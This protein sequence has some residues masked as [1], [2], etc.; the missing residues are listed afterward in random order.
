MMYEYKGYT[1]HADENGYKIVEKSTG[2]EVVNCK[3]PNIT[4]A[5]ARNQVEFIVERL[6]VKY[7][8]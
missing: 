7:D 5:W 1:V 2:V 3:I 4:E 8:R 6:G